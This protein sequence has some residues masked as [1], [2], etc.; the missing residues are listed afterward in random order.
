M[1]QFLKKGEKVNKKRIA[2]TVIILLLGVLAFNY[3]SLHSEKLTKSIDLSNESIGGVKIQESINKNS[4]IK[5][6]DKPLR[7]DDNDLYDYYYWNGGLKT[8][9]INSV[10]NEGSIMRLII[11]G[12]EIK[13]FDNP[14]S[15]A[16]GIKL[17]D[18]KEKILSIYG[19]K[20]YKSSE[21][22]AKLL[23]ILITKRT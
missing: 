3:L 23:D 9:S 6:Y 1:N 5:Q 10:K 11:V 4:F 18:K 21:Q 16:K 19:N 7:K 15:T 12:T 17:G 22:G 8:A 2:L 20:Y 14:L 13:L